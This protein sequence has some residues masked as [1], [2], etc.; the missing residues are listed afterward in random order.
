L[1]YELKNNKET[2]YHYL[3]K[4][5]NGTLDISA[6]ESFYDLSKKATINFTKSSELTNE[7]NVKEFL[8]LL[9]SCDNIKISKNNL[10]SSNDEHVSIVESVI[11]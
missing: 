1:N 4:I 6:S 7:L 3:D 2:T 9:D 10:R 8:D 5:D 11:S